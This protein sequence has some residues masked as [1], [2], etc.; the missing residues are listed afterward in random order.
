[1]FLVSRS[2]VR[3]G[4]MVAVILGIARPQVALASRPA[5]T[6][7]VALARPLGPS[8]QEIGAGCYVSGGGRGGCGQLAA[9]HEVPTPPMTRP[10][11]DQHEGCVLAAIESG[12]RRTSQSGATSPIAV[13]GR[14][15]AVRVVDVVHDPGAA[16]PAALF[17]DAHAPPSPVT[18]V[19][20]LL[21]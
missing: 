14:R 17:H 10:A 20:G 11:A 8:H 19:A 12:R 21:A 16:A 3:I 1:M 4:A 7:R 18:D 6:V 2:V 9:H 5:T 13:A 15:R